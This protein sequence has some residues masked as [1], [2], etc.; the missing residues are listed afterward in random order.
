MA[1]TQ[2]LGL[3]ALRL[4]PIN[5]VYTDASEQ[6]YQLAI[7]PLASPCI[8]A[9]G[10]N[11]A[12][13]LQWGGPPLLKRRRGGRRPLLR[14]AVIDRPRLL[15]LCRR[16]RADLAQP[17]H[18]SQAAPAGR[19]LLLLRSVPVDNGRFSSGPWQAQQACQAAAGGACREGG[20]RA[21][22]LRLQLRARGGL[23]QLRRARARPGNVLL[24]RC[25]GRGLEVHTGVVEQPDGRCQI[26]REA[27][28]ARAGHACGAASGTTTSNSVLGVIRGNAPH[29]PSG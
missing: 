10:W 3:H 26:R 4:F 5:A 25:R 16:C 17:E 18:A 1:I 6:R 13:R 22:D 14:Q 2:A 15:L 9:E 21:V 7:Q 29:K 11:R 19:L 20:N 27:G 8:M 23:S 28:E 24:M 12:K